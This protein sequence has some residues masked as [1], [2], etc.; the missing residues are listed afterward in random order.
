MNIL[1]ITSDIPPVP[2][3]ISVFV[4]NAC[5][6]LQHHGHRVEVLAPMQSGV[7]GIS[8]EHPFPVHRYRCSGFLSSLIPIGATFRHCFQ[9]R[10]DVIFFG[11]FMSTHALGALL[12]SKLVGIPYLVL[13]HGYDL[14]GY[15]RMSKIDNIAAK[16][17]LKNASWVFANSNYTRERAIALGYDFSKI[18]VVN[19]GVDLDR[20]KPG[21]EVSDIADCY[22]LHGKKVI[23]TVSRLDKRKAHADIL[24]ALPCVIKKIPNA[25][26]LIAGAGPEKR[27][28]KAMV[29]ELGLHSHVAF[30]GHVPDLDLPAL[31]CACD[32]FVMPSL[33]V[34]N[35][36]EGFG[37]V[38]IEASACGKPVVGSRSGGIP[39][40]VIDGVTGQLVEPGDVEGIAQTL[41]KLLTESQHAY[42]LGTN[43]RKRAERE[44]GWESVGEILNTAL[45]NLDSKTT[46]R[47]WVKSD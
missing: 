43:G 38:F 20:F 25:K 35:S 22:G 4:F 36:F 15:F 14:D 31:Y 17:V 28:L 19:P 29:D 41:I 18:T 37:I 21:I 26:Y 24:R 3:G 2:G 39:D 42:S 5:K 47:R 23:L 34:G 45:C 32:L 10:V 9:N 6:Q 16:F 7:Q 30:T 13:V 8:V 11:L 40:A 12:L 27:G 1:V 46:S 33:M 44:F